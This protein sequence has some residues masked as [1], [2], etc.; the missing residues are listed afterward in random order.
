MRNIKIKWHSSIQEIPKIIWNT[1]QGEN[2]T[3]FYKWDWLNALEASDSVSPKYGWQPLFLSAWRGKDL[4]ACAPLYLKSHSYGEFIFDNAFCQLAQDMGLQYY[5]KLIGMSPLSPIEG[6]RFLFSEGV[7]QKELTKILFSEIDIFAKQNGILSSNFLYVDPKWMIIAESQDC[8]KWI[9][10]Q[11]VL[12][13]NKEKNFSDFLQKFNSNQRRNIKRERESI[14]KCGV[15]IDVLSGSEINTINLKKMH[16]FYQLHCSKWGVWGSKY[17]TES[18]FIELASKE[19]KKNIILFEAKEEQNEHTIGMS[20]CV[21]NE[22][23]LWGRYWG[24]DKN[25]DCLHFEACY[26]SPIEWAIKNKIKYFDPGAGGS[27]KKR[28]GFIAKPNSSLHRWYDI[29]MDSL[30]REW[31]PKANKLMLNQINATNNE[32]PF[33]FEEPKLSNT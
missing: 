25:I 23:M 28:R 27:H 3:P 15:K 9:N 11:S 8:A 16:Y 22:D 13:L 5:P 1:F 29:Q 7:D 4:I 17:L 12:K 18:F 21:R 19:L 30:I 20:L 33:K 6:Y 31:L 24:S 2:A 26:Y 10:Q 32:V 14:K